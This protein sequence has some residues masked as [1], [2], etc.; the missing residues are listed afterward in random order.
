[1]H[2]YHYKNFAYKRMPHA[3]KMKQIIKS[4]TLRTKRTL[5]NMLILIFRK[6]FL[7]KLVLTFWQK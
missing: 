1:M 4:N 5:W 7:S 3:K 6:L 2:T